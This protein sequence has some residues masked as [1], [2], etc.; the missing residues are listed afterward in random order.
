MTSRLDG[1]S[2]RGLVVRSTDTVDGR[3]VVVALTPAGRGIVDDAFGA[4]LEAERELLAPLP[5]DTVAPLAATL[6]ALLARA[7]TP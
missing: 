1:L 6:R 2:A 4:L 5:P 3:L 7:E